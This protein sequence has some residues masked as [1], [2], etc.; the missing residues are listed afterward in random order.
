MRIAWVTPFSHRSAIGRVSSVV[1]RALSDK[2]HEVIIVRSERDQNDAAPTH[3]TSLPVMWWHDIALRDLEVSEDVVVLNFG[4]NYDFHAGAV[5][6]ALMGMNFG[7]FHDFFLYNLFNRWVVHNS[8]DEQMHNESIRFIYGECVSSLAEAAWNNEARIEEIAEAIP[9]TEW[10][11]TRCG[12]ALAHSR[13]YVSRLRRSCPGPTAV[14]PLCFES[15]NVKPL[16]VRHNDTLTI[17]TL[18]VINPN[19]CSDAIIKSIASSPR[20][21]QCCRFRLV[22]AISDKEEARLRALCDEVGF[23]KLDILGPVDDRTLVAELERADV[24]TCLR[25]P[26]LE[27]GSASAIEG[28]KAGR[29]IIVADAGFYADL[30]DDVVFKIP[31]SIDIPVLTEVLEKLASNEKLRRETG[32]RAR[33]WAGRTFAVESYVEILEPLMEQFVRMKPLLA[34]GERVAQQLTAIGANGGDPVIDIL[35]KKMQDLFGV[36]NIEPGV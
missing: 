29:P 3:P 12:A 36:T 30:P 24:L 21:Q 23:E 31:G 26:V 16:P 8:F 33:D 5:H 17:T 4:D 28:M 9:M 15:R 13:F 19:K 10:L 7:I 20:L 1:T 32:V 25:N 2:N 34:V 6:Y 35:A 11:A 18:G 22:G 27:G 14:A